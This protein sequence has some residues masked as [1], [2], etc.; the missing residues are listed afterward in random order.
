M[1]LCRNIFVI[2]FDDNYWIYGAELFNSTN[3]Y[4]RFAFFPILYS[5]VLFYPALKLRLCQKSKLKNFMHFFS[6]VCRS[7]WCGNR[8]N[9]DKRFIYIEIWHQ[10]LNSPYNWHTHKTVWNIL[11]VFLSALW[12][13]CA[14]MMIDFV[15]VY[16]QFKSSGSF[17]DQCKF[18]NWPTSLCFWKIA[19]E[20]VALKWWQTFDRINRKG[21]PIVCVEQWKWFS[22]RNFWWSEFRENFGKCFVWGYKEKWSLHFCLGNPLQSHVRIFTNA[23]FNSHAMQ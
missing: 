15:V 5:L 10:I 17:E 19:F 7:Q 18:R 2:I 9:I 3:L 11:Y 22:I 21:E 13:K 4:F 12:Y 20:S 6:F 8:G 16:S 14:L 1:N 23:D